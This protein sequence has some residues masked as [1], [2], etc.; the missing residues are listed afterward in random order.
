MIRFLLLFGFV[1]IP[2]MA[3]AVSPCMPREQLVEQLRNKYGETVFG[4][5]LQNPGQLLEIW[6][7]VEN[8]TFTVFITRPNGMS[9]ITASGRHWHQLP[10]Q[11]AGIDG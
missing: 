11:P 2:A 6:S 7:S 4:G 10:P 3:H 1:C 8:G 9:C 5:G